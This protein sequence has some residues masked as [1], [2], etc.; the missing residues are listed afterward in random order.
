MDKCIGVSMHKWTNVQL[1]LPSEPQFWE[2]FNNSSFSCGRLG[3]FVSLLM[4]GLFTFFHHKKK[5]G[6]RFL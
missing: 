5:R 3:S 2:E 6:F 1:K 4:R